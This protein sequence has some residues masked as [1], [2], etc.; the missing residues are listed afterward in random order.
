VGVDV[1]KVASTADGTGDDES[2][3]VWS[4]WPSRDNP[5]LSAD[6]CEEIEEALATIRDRINPV[7]ALRQQRYS[8]NDLFRD[9]YMLPKHPRVRSRLDD[10]E[11]QRRAL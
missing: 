8:G 7:Q 1:G 10:G 6:E 4:A 11:H 9:V 5:Y 2:L 3:S